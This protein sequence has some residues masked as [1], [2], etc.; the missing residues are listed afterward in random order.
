MISYAQNFEDIMLWR[1][2]RHVKCGYYVDV[3]A[4]HPEIDS[5]TKW[6]YDQGWTGVNVEPVQESFALLQSARPNDRNICAAAGS[7]VGVAQMTVFHQS[8]GLSCLQP[9]AAELQNLGEHSVIE[10]EVITLNDILQ[11]HSGEIH[12]LKI[13]AEGSERDVLLGIDLARFRP[14]I[15]L[16]EATTPL[17]SNRSGSS[18]RNIV[19]ENNYQHAYFDGLNEFFVA[20]EK[21]ELLEPFKT[22]PNVFD[23]FELATF[24]REQ[25]MLAR[26]QQLRESFESSCNSLRME[27]A[28]QRTVNQKTTS[29]LQAVE[30]K[31]SALQSQL[32]RVSAQLTSSQEAIAKLGRDV[33][34]LGAALKSARAQLQMIFKS[35]SWRWLAPVRKANA[36]LKS[37]RKKTLPRS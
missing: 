37:Y 16:V 19:L 27:L 24:R 10:V 28:G 26:E 2:L 36:V 13:D 29:A 8:K 17:T 23:E 3:G 20:G 34:E 7:D 11:S 18:W 4:F 33:S 25:Q 12:F 35:R 15:I 22:P 21:S 5:V 6:F 32:Q 31:N 9:T 30:S 14:W 1:A